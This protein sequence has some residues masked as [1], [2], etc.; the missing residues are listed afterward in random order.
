MEGFGYEIINEL[1]D[2]GKDEARELIQTK[3]KTL[4]SLEEV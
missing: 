3:F 2:I 1:N 4:A